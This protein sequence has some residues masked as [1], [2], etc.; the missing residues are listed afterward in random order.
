MVADGWGATAN[1]STARQAAWNGSA[2]QQWRITHRGDGRHS[3]ANRGTG[4]VLDG[5]GT[6]ASGSVAKQWAYD[7]STN[8]LWTFTAL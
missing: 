4:M 6:V 2:D 5:A 3:I 8:L 7:G 1:G